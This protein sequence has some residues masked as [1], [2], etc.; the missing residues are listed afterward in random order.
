MYVQIIDSKRTYE[1]A[2]EIGKGI[3]G[4]TASISIFEVIIH[5]FALLNLSCGVV[6]SR[7]AAKAGGDEVEGYNDAIPTLQDEKIPF[8]TCRVRNLPACCRQHLRVQVLPM[9]QR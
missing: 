3:K 2:L 4:A 9:R 5:F 8:G 1:C 7:L 6:S